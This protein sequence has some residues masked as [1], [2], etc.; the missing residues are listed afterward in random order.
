[1]PRHPAADSPNDYHAS[2]ARHSGEAILLRAVDFGE[3]DRIVHLLTPTQGRVT[4]IA[5]GARRSVKRFPG[6]LDLFN[7]LQITLQHRRTRAMGFLEQAVLLSP[8]IGLRAHP[9]RYALASYIL[10]LFDRMAPEG[11]APPDARRIFTFALSALTALESIEPDRPLRVLVELRALDALGLRPELRRCVRC[12]TDARGRV[13][14][15]VADGGVICE[16]CGTGQH[17]VLPV[18]LGTLRML[19][20]GLDYAWD[21]LARL[22]IDSAALL[23]AEQLLFRF[24]RFHVG[25]ELRSESFLADSLAG[26]RLTPPPA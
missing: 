11:A 21:R 7:H 9:V 3:S 15:H 6:T 4:A 13:G 14:F 1:M 5:K 8:F 22:S 20:Q 17:G 16:R 12:G 19:E 10:E 18:H 23:E 25:F 2:M 24:Q 26:D